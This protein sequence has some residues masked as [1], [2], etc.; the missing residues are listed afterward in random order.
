M[1]ALQVIHLM[2]SFQ[3]TR[4]DFANFICGRRRCAAVGKANNQRGQHGLLGDGF[5]D[6]P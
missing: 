2:A 1:T 6:Q 3:V 5:S 4:S